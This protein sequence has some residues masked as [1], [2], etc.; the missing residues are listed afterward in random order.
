MKES[1]F[2]FVFNWEG[3]K[4][5]AMDGSKQEK[6]GQ[7]LHEH[8]WEGGYVEIHDKQMNFS[9]TLLQTVEDS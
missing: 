6:L 5:K 7:P 9:L 4:I 3:I 8:R 2:L 1:Y